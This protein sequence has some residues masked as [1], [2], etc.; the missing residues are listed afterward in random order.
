MSDSITGCTIY[1]N[2]D[3]SIFSYA[4]TF[5]F[6]GVTVPSQWNPVYVLA[7]TLQNPT[8]MAAVKAAA[9]QQAS[10]NKEL[11]DSATTTNAIN[12]SVTL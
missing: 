1:H 5:S 2:A 6:G 4:V 11:C 10:I 3:G 12:G 9:C 7:S 8:D